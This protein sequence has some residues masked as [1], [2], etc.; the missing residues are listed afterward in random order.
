MLGPQWGTPH[1]AAAA[2]LDALLALIELRLAFMPGVALAKE[3]QGLPTADPTQEAEVMARARERA[4]LLHVAP[5]R[6]AA[7]FDVL[8]ATSRHIQDEFRSTPA[9]DRPVAET[10]DLEQEARPALGRIS[11]TIVARAA[12][13]AHGRLGGPQPTPAVLAD[14][15]DAS[16]ASPEDRLAIASAV[17]ALLPSE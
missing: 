13:V 1:G 15:L 17:V 11:A 5:D 3:Q 7:L 6:I 4:A 16:L 12:D 2:D 8:I 10:M 9:T 14:A